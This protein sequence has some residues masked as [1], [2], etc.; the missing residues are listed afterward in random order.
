[1]DCGG[2]NSTPQCGNSHAPLDAGVAIHVG[3]S[4]KRIAGAAI[5]SVIVLLGA[6]IGAAAGPFGTQLTDPDCFTDNLDPLNPPAP[7]DLDGVVIDIAMCLAAAGAHDA[8]LAFVAVGTAIVMAGYA[9]DVAFTTVIGALILVYNTF[10]PIYTAVDD[11]AHL[12]VDTAVWGAFWA[13][14]TVRIITNDPTNIP[15]V[16]AEYER[17]MDDVGAALP[18]VD[19]VADWVRFVLS[20][21]TVGF[22]TIGSGLDTLTEPNCLVHTGSKGFGGRWSPMLPSGMPPGAITIY[23]PGAYAGTYPILTVPTP[24]WEVHGS[25]AEADLK[26]CQELPF[27]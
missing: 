20:Q 27:P 17:L 4:G 15:I 22:Q 7:G 14:N 8:G 5:L 11:Y 18:L 3:K 9:D 19:G 2:K 25:R 26:P 6:S 23:Y 24:A 21:I 12:A 1:M 13:Y 10:V 16:D